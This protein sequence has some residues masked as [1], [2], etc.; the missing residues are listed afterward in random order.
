[1]V[2]AATPR[3][4]NVLSVDVEEYFHAEEVQNSSTRQQLAAALSRVE[5][6]VT[7]VLDLL[8]QQGVKAT[9]FIVG[10]VA[11]AHPGLIAEIAGAGHE[12]GCHSYSHRLISRLTP[13]EF[14]AD[15]ERA[16][17]AIVDS[18]GKTPR[19]YRAPSYSITRN[20]MWALEV[21]VQC[22]F[23]HDS[24]I[25]P[26]VHDRYGIPGF[27]RHAQ[28]IQTPAGPICE[29]P[30]ATVRLSARHVVPVGGGGYL[31]LLPYSYTSAGLRRINA[32]EHEAGCVYFHPWELDPDQPRLARGTLSRLRTYTGLK[33][34]RKKIA[35]LLADFQFS[36]LTEVHHLKNNRPEAT[37]GRIEAITCVGK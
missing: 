10:E 14:R 4:V 35:R 5:T 17:R 25:Y 19:V 12:I 8:G 9:F 6:Q 22:G 13:E 30:I 26:I 27:G 3:I 16:V 7:A 24:S 18:C 20:T 34:M 21:L 32:E 1:M 33:G 23:T 31:R 2:M 28:T 15:T 36:P 37:D 11:E 29:V